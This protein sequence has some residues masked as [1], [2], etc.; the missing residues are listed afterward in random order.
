MSKIAICPT[1]GSKA[2]IRGTGKS[3]TYET[4]QD[5]LL[6]KKVEQLKKAMQKHKEKAE[7]LE[8]Q[9]DEKI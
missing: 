8:K 2:Q 3:V 6:I 9:L 4:L 1:F 7:Q 5:D